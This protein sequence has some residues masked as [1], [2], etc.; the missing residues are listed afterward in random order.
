MAKRRSNGE[1]SIRKRSDSSWEASIQVE[2]KRLYVYG[3]SRSETKDK[4]TQIQI[5]VQ[6]DEL[7]DDSDMTVEDWMNTW[8]DCY[9]A[10]A[11]QSTKARYRQ[12]IR[13]HIIPALGK[14]KVQELK[15][16]TV[17]R[18]LN[19]CKEKKGL[20]EKSLK[21]IY[22]VLNKAMTRAQKDGLIKKNPCA[23]AEIPAYENPQKEMRPLKDT[24]VPAFL[25]LISGHPFEQLYFIAMF[26]GMRESEIIGLTWD[27]IDWEK[28][29]I[30]L[31]RQYKAVRGEEKTY[32]FTNLKNKQ[33]RTFTVPSS[34]IAALKKV[35]T[36][37][38]EWK[39][40]YGQL[41]RNEDGFVFTDELG[42]HLAT[43]TVYNRFKAIVAQ[44]GLPE[45]RLHDLRHT[46]ATLALQNGVD[47]KT[48]SHNLGHSTVA[49][50][51]DKYAHVTF[52][53]Q[54]DS[55]QKMESFIEAL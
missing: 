10:K 44:M 34:V 12:D 46:Y 7:I 52:T 43:R 11:K 14:T 21:S 36:K 5:D 17:Q 49:F 55:A 30:R 48:V 51:M 18:F 27:C 40:H 6:N 2:N 25:K 22:L 1:G 32:M 41:Y 24:E 4:L 19:M 23:D 47:I 29:T 53:M 3:K 16:L 20:S 38:A 8:I 13:C 26:T 35:R 31:Y 28:G 54:K 37:Q 50:T 9:T 33:E 45:V 42:H 15:T 39:L